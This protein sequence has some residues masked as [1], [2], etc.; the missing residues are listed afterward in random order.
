M[1]IRYYINPVTGLPHIYD[2]GVIE[3]D[4]ERVLRRPGEEGLSS[5]GSRQALGQAEGGRYLRVIYVPD[6]NGD[7]VF[8]I[9]AY[10]L[11]G[12]ELKAYRR[13]QRR[14]RR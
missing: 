6:D 14:R 10:P 3:A 2:H 7:G 8:V 11:A 4:V 5:N 1:E 9:T 12:R 13:R